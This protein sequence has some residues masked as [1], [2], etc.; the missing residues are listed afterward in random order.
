MSD[1]MFSKLVAQPPSFHSYWELFLRW[2]V[3]TD[4]T[5]LIKRWIWG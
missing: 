2:D 4:V 1:K 3:F 5:P